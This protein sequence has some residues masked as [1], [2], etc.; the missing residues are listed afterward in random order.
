MRRVAPPEQRRLKRLRRSVPS[1]DP[2]DPGYRRLWWV[3]YADDVLIAVAGPRSEVVALKEDLTAFLATI[4]L[5]LSETKTLIT[6]ATGGNARFLGH[7][8][9]A[10]TL[11]KPAQHQR[12]RTA[13]GGWCRRP[14][15]PRTAVNADIRALMAK[16]VERGYARRGRRAVP[17][18]CGRLIHHSDAM[19]V[20]HYRELARGQGLY[21]CGAT[22]W[23]TLRARLDY[24]LRY[25]CLLTLAAKHRLR[26][27]RKAIRRYGLELLVR[28]QPAAALRRGQRRRPEEHGPTGTGTVLASFPR[29]FLWALPVGFRRGAA[30]PRLTG[31]AWLENF[32]RRVARTR[33][34]FADSC[35]L[36]GERDQLEVH[37]LR[38]LADRPTFRPQPPGTGKRTG[39]PND[40]LTH[41]LRRLKRKQVML[42]G[43]CHRRVHAGKHGGSSPRPGS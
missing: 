7:L 13:T 9:S 30:G 34:L 19:I 6:S 38:R 11:R 16:L 41:R 18:R 35:T 32:S 36:C 43:P 20:E 28:E 21:Y 31:L 39:G 14:V 33:K 4:G 17:T 29:R 1:R 37:H 26:T 2:L 40:Y 23:P 25:S 12:V 42:C 8:I 5:R 27:K 3:R 10:P 24:V 22:N 15:K